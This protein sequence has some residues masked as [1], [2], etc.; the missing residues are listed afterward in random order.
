MHLFERESKTTCE[1]QPKLT[2][3]IANTKLT[4]EIACALEWG[5]SMIDI[6][7][8]GNEKFSTRLQIEM[9]E[10]MEAVTCSFDTTLTLSCS[11]IYNLQWLKQGWK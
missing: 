5:K 11:G 9:H 2:W 7:I 1:V 10:R 4:L 3:E 6:D 8:V